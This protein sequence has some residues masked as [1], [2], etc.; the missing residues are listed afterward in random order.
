MS[1]EKKDEYPPLISDRSPSYERAREERKHPSPTADPNEVAALARQFERAEHARQTYA[2]GAAAA[3]DKALADRL[4]ATAATHES[5]RRELAEKLEKLG[6]APP[7]LEDV[8]AQLTHGPRDIA[9]AIDDRGIE[10][11][12]SRLDAELAGG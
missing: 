9:D 5:T 12:L 8:R 3:K 6:A 2:A 4:A 11:A 10:A 7:R 1:P